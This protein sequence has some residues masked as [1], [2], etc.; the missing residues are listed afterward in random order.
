M[1]TTSDILPRKSKAW[2]ACATGRFLVDIFDVHFDDEDEPY[3]TIHLA[4]GMERSTVRA[5]L[6]PASTEEAASSSADATANAQAAAVSA[7]R[8]TES[9]LLEAIA[10]LGGST[11]CQDCENE[12]PPENQQPRPRPPENKQPRRPASPGKGFRPPGS[13][14]RASSPG[15]RKPSKPSAAPDPAT[16]GRAWKDEKEAATAATCMACKGKKK[17]IYVQ[18]AECKRTVRRQTTRSS[19]LLGPLF[20]PPPNHSG[21]RFVRVTCRVSPSTVVYSV[22][23][24]AVLAPHPQLAVAWS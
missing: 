8:T 22:R 10:L 3:Y 13:T 5:R 14:A 18:C 16:G 6:T 7:E 9:A 2:Y 12:P 15:R 20:V 19:G 11:E 17:P 24:L 4:D 21:V 1:A 23:A